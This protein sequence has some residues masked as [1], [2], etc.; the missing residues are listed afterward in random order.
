MRRPGHRARRIRQEREDDE[1]RRETLR[2]RSAKQLTS[3]A[4]TQLRHYC[5]KS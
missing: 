4:D 3:P 1:T 2:I 5:T